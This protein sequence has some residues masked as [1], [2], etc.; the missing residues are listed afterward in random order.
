MTAL[1]FNCHYNG[2][3]IIQEL[4]WR[5]V[6]VLA[7]DCV[8]SVGTYSRFARFYRCPNPQTEESAFINYL[9]QLGPQFVKKPVLFPTNDH[10]AVAVS[11]H[12]EIL[13]QYYFPCVA[14]YSAVQLV[15]EKQR[16][17]DWALANGYP[18]PRSWQSDVAREIPDESF[19]LA[20]KP[21]YRRIASN[22][23]ETGDRSRVFDQMRLTVL[24]NRE[25][26]K[27]FE[28][29]HRDLL[30]Y[31]LFQEYV[32]GLSDSMF[33]V[34]IYADRQYKV[35]GMFTGRKVRGYPPD[36]GDCIVGQVEEMPGE[37]KEL[38]KSMCK[39]IGYHGIA[40][41]EFKR[42]I[43]SGQYKIIEIN[44]RSWSWIGIT[45]ACGVSLP[46]IAYADLTSIENVSYAESTA[47]TGSVKYVKI[48]ED[49]KNCLYGY[50]RL[51]FHEWNMT[52]LQWWKSLRAEKIICA[53]FA[54]DD[55]LIGIRA[56]YDFLKSIVAVLFRRGSA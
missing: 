12:K 27:A 25:E 52:P 28:Q 54:K 44:P 32:P 4:G 19:P 6:E 41:F 2:L 37:I 33:T 8:R 20:A 15:I 53:E 26:L 38:V 16:F 10:W 34:G 5:G 29:R 21:E 50:R 46:W 45:P 42:D 48:L 55:I 22:D 35:K 9:M 18:A 7:L 14:D 56:I 51:G 23:R 43:T 31:F 1:V 3:S 39:E 17:H 11:R 47:P 40:E 36:I 49:M 30:P 24:K 13:S